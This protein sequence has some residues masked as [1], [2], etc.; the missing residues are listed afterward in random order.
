MGSENQDLEI[1][2]AFQKRRRNRLLRIGAVLAALVLSYFVCLY[3]YAVV[4]ITQARHQGVYPTAEAAAIATYS[5]G[6]GGA[7]VKS[8]D[9]INCGPNEPSGR[10]AFISCLD[11]DGTR[12]W[13]S[14][15]PASPLVLFASDPASN[16]T[17]EVGMG[18]FE[19]AYGFSHE[20]KLLWKFM[21][22]CGPVRP[23]RKRS[24][25]SFIP[26][27]FP[28]RSGNHSSPEK[29]RASISSAAQSENR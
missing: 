21:N 15:L 8:I 16:G 1:I 5:Q 26:V 2:T 10:P 19:Y 23:L 14:P 17:F 7:E 18:A 20:G 4:R 6:F 24:T 22:A 9:V 3:T 27:I 29:V 12:L 13:E 28:F 25:T 11:A